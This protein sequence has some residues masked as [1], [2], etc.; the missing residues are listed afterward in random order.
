MKISHSIDERMLN[1]HIWKQLVFS[2]NILCQQWCMNHVSKS[3]ATA[4][5]FTSENEYLI[6]RLWVSKNSVAKQLLKMLFDRRW[7]LDRL[8]TLID[9]INK[10]CEIFNFAD[11]C[12]WMSSVWST[13]TWTWVNDASTVVFSV[14]CL[15]RYNSFLCLKKAVCFILFI[16][17]RAFT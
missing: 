6:K 4:T 9:K 15:I 17:L 1:I 12:N 2:L 11:F 13:T 14:K 3:A 16:N 10:K 8:N 7:K 5:G